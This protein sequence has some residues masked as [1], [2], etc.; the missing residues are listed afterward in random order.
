MMV[1]PIFE[2]ISSQLAQDLDLNLVLPKRIF[3]ALQPQLPQPS[4]DF[5][6]IPRALGIALRKLPEERSGGHQTI[7]CHNPMDDP[8]LV[9]HHGRSGSQSEVDKPR[10]SV[11]TG[12]RPG[13]AT[14]SI[15]PGACYLI[16]KARRF[17]S[18]LVGALGLEPRTR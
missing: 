1:T 7:R 5:H 4:G 9:H 3:I 11:S 10:R 8:D 6:G 17:L 16:A 2:S 14:A 18:K 13:I 12:N 15:S